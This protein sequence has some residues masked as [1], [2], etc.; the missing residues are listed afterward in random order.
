MW[1][2]DVVLS[3]P[4]LCLF[5]HLI[6]TVEAPAIQYLSA[7]GAFESFDESILCWFAWLGEGH[8]N[9]PQFTPLSDVVAGEFWPIVH[10]DLLWDHSHFNQLLEGTG[11]VL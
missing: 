6:K 11:N 4:L 9:I 1:S 10:S 2:F 3:D 7:V 5:S 8:L